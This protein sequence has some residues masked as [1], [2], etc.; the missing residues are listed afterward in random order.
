MSSSSS[1]DLLSTI[2]F[3]FWELDINS[4]T[5]CMREAGKSASHNFLSWQEAIHPQDRDFLV[6]AV[7]DTINEKRGNFDCQFRLKGSDGGWIMYRMRGAP[8]RY[9]SAKF[10]K[11]A[12]TLE[13]F[14]LFEQKI[15]D[16][17]RKVSKL[18]GQAKEKND[19]FAS[20][21]HELRT[22]M[23]GVLGIADLLL[24]SSEISDD[25]RSLLT[26]LRH[27]GTTLL[28]LIND[29][30]DLA[31]L[32][33]RKLTLVPATFEIR[34]F[35]REIENLFTASTRQKELTFVAVVDEAVPQF[36]KADAHR[37]QQVLVNLIGNAQKFTPLG[38]GICL[39]V[40]VD[41]AP[42][43]LSFSVADSGIGIR[44]ENQQ[45][46][47]GEYAQES[48]TTVLQ[49]GG[50]GLGLSIARELVTLFGGDLKV[51]SEPGR[52]TVFQFSIPGATVQSN[53]IAQRPVAS[54]EQL[55]Q[56]PLRILLAED[57]P[58]NQKVAS[59]M[60]EKNGHQVII[61]DNGK[62]AIEL[63]EKENF[64]LILMDIQMPVMSGDQ[65]TRMIREK[66]Q[67]DSTR[68]PIPIIALTAHAMSGDREKYLALGMDDYVSKP[69]NRQALFEAIWN[70][71]ESDSI[72]AS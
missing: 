70:V 11:L 35:I 38:G 17:Q 2:E 24:D 22:P 46:I 47:F 69:I 30:L 32:E 3:V 62:A 4:L 15:T 53:N 48:D 58:V 18:E 31:K 67:Q 59:R 50:T 43:C 27:C 16:L 72:S 64:D 71:V 19:F 14:S 6:N 23:T 29:T 45:K 41:E 63:H 68:R 12:G 44:S 13:D 20:I 52:G 42:G 7:L 57:N 49:F 8:M 5:L 21:T 1:I 39:R 61:A 28:S 26:S 40:A 56:R 33:A 34:T 65:A 37:L 10:T 54:G 66:E 60:L 9:E 25:Q 51:R 36:L 55:A